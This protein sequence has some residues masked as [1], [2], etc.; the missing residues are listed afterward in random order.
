MVLP[1]LKFNITLRFIAYLMILSFLP[2]LA[3][4]MTAIEV[5]RSIL[6]TE[7]S[8]HAAQQVSSQQDYLHVEM[9][10]VESLIAN[11]S[12]V[13]TIAEALSQS[14]Q[15]RDSFTN[16]ATQARI[17]YIL[18]SYLNIK[19]LVSID[20]FTAD[21]THYH[22]GDTLDTANTRQDVRQHI[23]EGALA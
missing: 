1:R 5:S 13:D 17:G 2:I 6:A 21:G 4:G 8:R 16:L 14:G 23:Y 22:V 18:N 20:I 19:G 10:Q 11:I 3:I 9:D 7:A 12:G 15:P